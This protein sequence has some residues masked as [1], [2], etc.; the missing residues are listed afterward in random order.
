MMSLAMYSSPLLPPFQTAISPLKQRAA[1][2]KR[3]LEMEKALKT[4]GPAF[5]LLCWL[6]SYAF[7]YSLHLFQPQFALWFLHRMA[8]GLARITGSSMLHK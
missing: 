8:T 4:N 6:I 2:K 7:G 5:Q 3:N 1:K